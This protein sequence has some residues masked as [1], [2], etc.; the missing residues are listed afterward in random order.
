MFAIGKK[1]MVKTTAAFDCQP[2]PYHITNIGA[3]PT[4]G[5]AACAGGR[6]RG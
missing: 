5:S 6:G 4:M 1:I 2:K 3:V